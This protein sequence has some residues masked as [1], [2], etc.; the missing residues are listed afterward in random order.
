MFKRILSAVSGKKNNTQTTTVSELTN[1]SAPPATNEKTIVAYDAYGRELRI[2]R[3]EWRDKIFLPSLRQK[4]DS[5]ADLYN[6]ILSGLNDGFAS[7]LIPAAQ[8]LV[9]IDDNPERSHVIQG[10]VLMKNGQ[11]AAAESTLRAGMA[12]AG[13]TGSLLTNLAKVFVGSGDNTRADETLWQAVQA[14]PNLENGLIWWASI[15]R[16]RGGD[17]AYLAAL[18][19]AAAL[20]G[21]WRAQL[22]LARHH[23]EH[24]EIEAARDLYTEVLAGGMFDGDSLMM[25]SGDLGKNGEIALMVELVA[26]V[27][28][29]LKHAPMAGINLLRA[30]QEL[31][32]T[33]QGEKLLARIYSL[34]FA[35]I[36]QHLDGFAQAFAKMRSQVAQTTPVDPGKLDIGTLSLTQPIWHYGLCKA[37]WLFEQKPDDAQNIGFF[38]LA[39]MMDGTAGPESQREDDLGRLTRAIPLY[40]AEAAHYWSNYATT[41]YFQI[42]KGG[43][44]VVSGQGFDGNVLFDM[45]PPTMR[46][47][48]SGEIGC[49]GEDKQRQWQISLSLWDCAARVKQACESGQAAEAELGALILNLEQRLLAHVGLRREQP[50]DVFYLRPSA[51][52]MPVYLTELG[53]AFTL[54]L[55]ANEWM[56]RSVIWGERSML[57]WPLNMALH[58]P[59]VA[60]PKLMYIS[61][62]SKAFDYKSE[63]LGEYKERSLELLREAERANS[64]AFRL[65]PLVWK[66]F[67]MHEEFNG[68]RQNLPA[69]TSEAYREWLERVSEM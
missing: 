65:A 37:D 13:A 16:E 20:P 15:A 28:D 69:G 18:R 9:E 56:P 10:I 46:Y 62:L 3:G 53:Q 52:A 48:V 63:V 29:E 57:D 34:A 11:F 8:R 64:P 66:I 61:G 22:W 5:A 27:Y 21:S 43:G 33:D 42:V 39:K 36:K 14:D 7:D 38:A 6:A 50:L 55:V 60:I 54:T 51:E 19:T 31:G 30:Y 58:W 2:T 44:P 68:H 25:I 12:K 41:C 47:F 23:L 4:W 32:N 17:V 67:G 49:S 24:K 1:A 59:S 40:L 35:P 45:V 26:P